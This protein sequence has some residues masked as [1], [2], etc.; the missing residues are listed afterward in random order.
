MNVDEMK[1][2]ERIEALV[3]G[4]V[5]GMRLD[6]FRLALLASLAATIA[7]ACSA[8]RVRLDFLPPLTWAGSTKTYLQRGHF[9]IALL[10]QIVADRYFR[11]GTQK[12]NFVSIRAIDGAVPFTSRWLDIVANRLNG[13]CQSGSFA[14]ITPSIAGAIVDKQCNYFAFG[15]RHDDF[16]FNHFHFLHDRNLIITSYVVNRAN[17]NKLKANR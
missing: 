2:G 14:L 6:Y 4:K 9:T 10:S 13:F 7:R 12:P 15:I 8:V 5:M 16:R 11:T 17:Q 3:A 1:A